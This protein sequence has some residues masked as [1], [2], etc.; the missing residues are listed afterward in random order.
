MK[1]ILLLLF[2]SSVL[3]QNLFDN[4]NVHSLN[5]QFYNPNYDPILQNNWEN[6]DKTYELATLIFNDEYYD[7]VGV[8]Y[9]G[10]STFFMT[11]AFGNP[12]FPL[13]I[14]LD[15]IY[16]SQNL[17]GYKKIKLSNSIF[18]PTFVKETI[19]YL[20]ESFY[21]PTPKTGYI[22]VSIND[23]LLGLYVSV[24]S[25]NKQFLN[26]NFGNND[27]PFF[28][29]E[30]QFQFGEEYDAWPDLVWY[31]DD[32]TAYEY[33]KG[34]ELKSESGW[35]D[36][37]E[38]IYTLNFDLENIESVLNVDRVLWFLAASMVMPDL[39][40]YNGVYMHNFY[41]YKNTSSNQFE[42]IPW[43]K[44]NTFGGAMI[45]TII[46]QGGSQYTIYHWDPFEFENNLLRP[47]FSQLMTIPLYKK[48]YTAHLN[49]II[50][51]I[52][53]INYMQELAYGLQNVVEIY[54][55][56]DPNLFF[57][58]TFGNYFQFNVDNYLAT[59]GGGYWC[60]ITSTIQPRLNY[61]IN[62]NQLSQEPPTIYNVNQLNQNPN[63][64]EDVIVNVEVLNAT[65][66]ELMYT[67]NSF[68]S[69]FISVPMV[70][71]GESNDENANDN[72]YTTV[73]PFYEP[74]Y[75]VKYYIRAHNDNAISLMP[76]RAENI[77]YEYYISFGEPLNNSIVINEINYN[78]SSSFDSG[79]WLELYN[80][81]DEI[82]DL[83]NWVFK[84]E[85]NDN[86]FN[87]PEG[88][89]ISPNSYLVLSNNLNAFQEI[90][91]DI[92]NIIG[93]FD[94]GLSGD[95]EILR[96]YNNTG[97]LVDIVDYKDSFPWPDEPDGNGPTLELIDPNSDN[98]S[99]EN[100]SSSNEVGTPGLTN[101]SIQ[102][103]GD[104]NNDGLINVIDV[105]SIVNMILGISSIENSAD[106]NQDGIINV[107]DILQIVNIIIVNIN[108][109]ATIATIS[110]DG[111]SLNISGDG[112]I[113][114]VQMKISH[115]VDFELN[116]NKDSFVS[117]YITDGKI[118]SIIVIAPQN[119]KIFSTSNSFKIDEV[120]VTNSYSSIDVI[121]PS[122]FSIDKVYPNPFNPVTNIEFSLPR[123]IEISINI[124]DLRG[125]K[126][127]TL[128]SGFKSSGIH[129][130][131][132]N[133]VGYSSGIYFLKFE[134]AEFKGTQKLV[135]VK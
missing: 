43:D 114:G 25:I 5:I 125:Q 87:I 120:L 118:T 31:G 2:I 121:H 22:N 119:E 84:D 76:E 26:E 57:P 58:F 45:N 44:D 40:T 66:V 65:S 94:F 81:T 89:L 112:Y 37:L 101:D 49:T 95:G 35:S 7:S 67:V 98:F 124:Y 23:Q 88:I 9:K 80:N 92:D 53:N 29:C 59:F 27:G 69:H 3:A 116:L 24:E 123:D 77:F 115:G 97:D 104:I 96:L 103:F 60:G 85:N 28:K 109:D 19:G 61:L 21:L 102:L 51:E 30:P 34:Y 38:L 20:T 107:V 122:E 15:L 106:L 128:Y 54:S 117:E 62:H 50:D 64:G 127:Y 131:E 33:Q 79:D 18:D 55:E 17:L 74:G 90:H 130:I 108:V 134:S 75:D 32:S 78:S 113:G 14:D 12:K 1:K 42:I 133:A 47:L 105:V 68:P 71:D 6:N 13:N 63:Q 111:E 41:L 73:I 39:D 99:F 46:E 91:S 10:N 100:W 8:R 82:Q 48:I 110:I 135:L 36:L 70:D 16:Q 83:S 52:Y 132:W 86:F 93:E 4:Y 11:Q 129:T 126:I 72:I 56:N